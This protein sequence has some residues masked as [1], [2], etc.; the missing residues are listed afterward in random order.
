M[1]PCDERVKQLF[2]GIER[3]KIKG[4]EGG[5]ADTSEIG[6]NQCELTPPSRI[7]SSG[8]SPSSMGFSLGML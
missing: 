8:K 1:L 4:L 5:S 2:R 7:V 3:W 6:R